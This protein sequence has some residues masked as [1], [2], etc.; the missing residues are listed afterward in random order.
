MIKFNIPEKT[1]D[2]GF[3][4]FA[5]YVLN[6]SPTY[7]MRSHQRLGYKALDAITVAVKANDATVL[8]EDDFGTLFK[9]AVENTPIPKLFFY[10]EGKQTEPIPKT[11][12]TKFYEAV[13]NSETIND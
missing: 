11:F 13:E 3:L 9:T 1:I 12:F 4:E 7:E 6:Y 10:V 2:Y 8:M 5:T